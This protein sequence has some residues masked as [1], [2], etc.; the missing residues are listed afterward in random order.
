MTRI[1][2]TEAKIFKTKTRA[3][4]MCTFECISLEEVN[5]ELSNYRDHIKTD[6][7]CEMEF[8]DKNRHSFIS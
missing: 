4:I 8:M 5:Y 7:P 2:L 3:P 1:N 6:G